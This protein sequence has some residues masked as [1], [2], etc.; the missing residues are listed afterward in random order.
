MRLKIDLGTYFIDPFT[1]INY[2]VD[3]VLISYFDSIAI[4][5]CLKRTEEPNKCKTKENE[6]DNNNNNNKYEKSAK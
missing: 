2:T 3:T 6:K 5:M 4:A 1:R